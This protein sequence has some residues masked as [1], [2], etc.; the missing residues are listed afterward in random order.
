[1]WAAM[2]QR[3]ETQYAKSGDIHI[4]Y[5]VVGDG[6]VDLLYAQG[7]VS[8]VE[9]AWEPIRRRTLVCPTTPDKNI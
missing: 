9:Y 2:L 5:Q 8:N 3:P 1:M 7:W 4:A 6:P